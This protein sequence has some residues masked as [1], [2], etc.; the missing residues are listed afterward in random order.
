MRNKFFAEDPFYKPLKD[1]KDTSNDPLNGPIDNVL[2]GQQDEFSY[3]EWKNR[4][5][6]GVEVLIWKNVA[7]FIGEF[8]EDMMCGFGILHHDDRDK[9]MRYLEEFKAKGVGNITRKK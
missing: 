6:D 3:G 5:R 2:R 9:Y 1:T 7:K 8:L 4:K